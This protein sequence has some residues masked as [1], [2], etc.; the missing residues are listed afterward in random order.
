[1]SV[2]QISAVDVFNGLSTQNNS[3]LHDLPIMVY[4][5]LTCTREGNLRISS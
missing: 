1:M 2:L 3:E 5:M 4:D